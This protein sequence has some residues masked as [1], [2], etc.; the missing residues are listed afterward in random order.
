M[1]V[2]LKG[3]SAAAAFYTAAA[4]AASQHRAFVEAVGKMRDEAKKLDANS[5]DQFKDID[6]ALEL[7]KPIFE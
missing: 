3:I 5:A 7:L 4:Y 1:K 6:A 2:D